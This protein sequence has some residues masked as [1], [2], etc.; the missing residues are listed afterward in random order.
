VDNVVGK[1]IMIQGTSSGV[2]KTILS[3]ALCRIFKQDGYI[4]SPFKAQNITRNTY[5]IDGEEIAASQCLQALAS[6]SKPSSD[7][8]PIII[9]PASEKQSPDIILKGKHFD[10]ITAENQNEVKKKL[11]SEIMKSY[12]HLSGQN[13]IIVIE[14][15]GSPVEL[16]LNKEEMVNMGMAKFAKA[17]VILVSDIDRGGV[18]ASLY[19]TLALMSESE[20]AH[21]KACIVNRFSGEVTHFAE[22]IKI[23]EEII[24]LP[25]SGVIPHISINLPEEDSLPIAD[26]PSDIMTKFEDQYDNIAGIVRESLNMDLIYEILDNG[27]RTQ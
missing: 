24:S 20:K 1:S 10:K 26:A 12:S 6:G 2:G 15:A 13:D 23:L 21:V 8:N 22:G 25:V 9:K 7:M 19:G 14:G 4:V 5:F 16:N 17:P 18:F 3:L 11:H 27:M